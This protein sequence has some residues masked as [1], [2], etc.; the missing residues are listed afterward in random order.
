MRRACGWVMWA[1]LAVG[2]LTPQVASAGLLSVL[3]PAYANPA[4]PGGPTMWSSL[5]ATAGDAGRQF[6][7]RA[8]FNPASGPGSSREPNYLTLGGSGPLNDFRVAGGIAD[9][10]VP[11]KHIVA[12]N[13]VLRPIGDVKA[14]VDAYLTGFYAGYVDGIFFDDMSNDLADVGFYQDLQ[15]YVKSIKPDA[16]TFGNPGTTFVNNPSAQSTYDASDFIHSL[17]T[18]VVFENTQTEYLTN[19]TSFPHLLGLDDKRLAHIVHTTGAWDASLLALAAG[20][21]AGYVYFTDDV[22][23]NPYD[24]LTSYWGAMTRD[25]SA[26]NAAAVPEPASLWALALAAGVL[27]VGRRRRALR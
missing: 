2:G 17:D 14:D 3:A 21:G 1:C 25:I 6:E 15:T 7:L 18:I 23:F 24:E 9:G 22:M 10:Y 13:L 26:Y 16:R 4:S 5:I 12:G 20:R 8:I 27:V 19:Y 11:T